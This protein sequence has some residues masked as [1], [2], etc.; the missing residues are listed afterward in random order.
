MSITNKAGIERLPVD[1]YVI[2]G[3]MIHTY[4]EN[5]LGFKIGC[6]FTRWTGVTANHS[7]VKMRAVMSAKDLCANTQVSSDFAIRTLQE[8]AVGMQFKDTVKETLEKFMYPANM[9]SM[10]LTQEAAEEMYK[11]GLVAD[12][13]IEI[14]RYGKLTYVPQAGMFRVYLRPE[15]IIA[16][17]LSD[18]ET[19]AID[20]NM[21]ITGV[22]GTESDT[23]RWEVEITK[24]GMA[25]TET[26][27]LSIDK[28]FNEM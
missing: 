24:G 26:G 16:D 13:L 2:S 20:G 12:R 6:D 11:Y 7:Y 28:I 10:Q 18:P 17:M 15:R 14:A 4:L 9:E 27:I 22:F 23:I 5:Q 21:A 19:G 3:S 25:N 1:R 8:N